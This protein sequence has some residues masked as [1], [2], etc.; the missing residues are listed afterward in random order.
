MERKKKV[1]TAGLLIIVLSFLFLFQGVDA[2]KGPGIKWGTEREIIGQ[3]QTY[4]ISYGLYNPWDEDVYALLGVSDELKPI[5]SSQTS[6]AKLIKANT[7]SSDDVPVKLCFKIADN[8][9]KEDCLIGQVIC[10]QKCEESSKI[11]SGKILVMEK[12][13]GSS[14]GTAG[15]TTAL[16]VSVPLTLEI[17]CEKHSRDWTIVYV[18]II[19]IVA[20]LI[21]LILFRRHKRKNKVN[22]TAKAVKSKKKK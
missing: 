4:C 2:R 15:S 16:G 14:G 1:I 17:R 10:E 20:I 7:A 19:A 22:K 12:S 18:T 13:E 8:I 3:G 9:Y 6:D 11:Y 21:V 5:I